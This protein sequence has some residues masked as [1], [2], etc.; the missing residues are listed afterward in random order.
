MNNLISR[1]VLSEII[2][3]CLKKSNGRS[4]LLEVS[5]YVWDNY[6]NELRESGKIFYTWQYDLRWA[7]NELRKLGIMKNS[8]DKIYWVLVNKKD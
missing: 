3:E 1:K 7:A 6:E 4:T 5:K 2:I 8:A